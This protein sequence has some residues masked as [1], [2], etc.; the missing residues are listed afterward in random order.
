MLAATQLGIGTQQ[1]DNRLFSFY[2]FLIHYKHSHC[3]NKGQW[4]NPED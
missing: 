1:Y 2:I 3:F 4:L